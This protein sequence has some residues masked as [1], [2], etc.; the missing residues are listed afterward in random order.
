MG[1][2]RGCERF[3][4]PGLAKKKGTIL[5]RREG[6]LSQASFHTQCRLGLPNK[7]AKVEKECSDM[8]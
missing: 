1:F 3:E 7:M 6:G 8:K 4:A 2:Q 5:F